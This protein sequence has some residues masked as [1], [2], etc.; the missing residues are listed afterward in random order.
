[1]LRIINIIVILKFLNMKT[2]HKF[3][4]NKRTI[5][6]IHYINLFKAKESE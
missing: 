5:L 3:I 2:E 4:G 1:M 6:V